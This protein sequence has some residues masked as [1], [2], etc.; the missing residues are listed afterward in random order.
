MHNNDRD[1]SDD[2]T[3]Q[4]KKKTIEEVIEEDIECIDEMI[5]FMDFSFERAF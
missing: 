1:R 5:K 4:N 3:G 2:G